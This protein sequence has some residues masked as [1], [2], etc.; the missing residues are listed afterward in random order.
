MWV[1]QNAGR[2]GLKNAG[3]PPTSINHSDHSENP[4]QAG[5]NGHAL[6]RSTLFQNSS[7]LVRR[8]EGSLPAMMPAL[9]API[10]VP[11]IQSGSTPAINAGIIAGNEPSDRLTKLDEFW[12]RVERANTWPFEPAWTGFSEWSE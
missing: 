10:E 4:V 2:L 6:A 12:K 1:P 7:S 11:M 5:S 9:I 3:M 8:S